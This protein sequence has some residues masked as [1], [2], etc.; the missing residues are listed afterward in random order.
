MFSNERPTANDDNN[1]VSNKTA[2]LSNKVIS[3]MAS[4]INVANIQI[5]VTQFYCDPKYPF[6][7]NSRKTGI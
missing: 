2:S 3:R 1:L 6:R 7:R 5:D 4:L